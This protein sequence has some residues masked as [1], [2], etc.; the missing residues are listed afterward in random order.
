MGWIL[1]LFAVKCYR[2]E[3]NIINLLITI[4]LVE[5]LLKTQLGLTIG[6]VKVCQF[7]GCSFKLKP[8]FKT[9][10]VMLSNN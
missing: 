3:I 9:T 8:H 2:I 4:I 10:K 1:P 5:I 7:R 6:C